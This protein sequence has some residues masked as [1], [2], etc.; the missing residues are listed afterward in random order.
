MLVV[1]L[2]SPEFHHARGLDF[3]FWVFGKFLDSISGKIATFRA[4]L[5]KVLSSLPMFGATEINVHHLAA[6][7]FPS[8]SGSSLLGSFP[9]SP[10]L[11]N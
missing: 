8:G 1:P 11:I 4:S 3:S 5:D 7:L 9:V 6:F 10:N 2:F